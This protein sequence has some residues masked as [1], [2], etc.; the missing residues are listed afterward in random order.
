[1]VATSATTSVEAAP[2]TRRKAI[3]V[4]W[5]A[6]AGVAWL[7]LYA[8]TYLRW[9]TSGNVKPAP[10]GPTPIPTA[11]LVAVWVIEG[12]CVLIAIA[13]VSWFIIRPW[14]RDGHMSRDGLFLMVWMMMFF[15]HDTLFNYSNSVWTYSAAFVNVGSYA[16][17]IPGWQSARAHFMAV[18][19]LFGPGAYCV[20]FCY[21]LIG[22]RILRAAR[23]RWPWM[24]NA[25]IVGCLFL[26][27]LV[28]DVV[29]ESIMLHTGTM[30]Y[31]GSIRWMT[32]FAGHFYQFPV[33]EA[34]T[35]G[36]MQV[37]FGCV[38]FFQNDKGQLVA[39][40]GIEKLTTTAKRRQVWRFLAI[41]GLANCIFAVAYDIPW[42]FFA[43]RTDDW[44]RAVLDKSYMTSG[45]CGIGT[46]Y[47]CPGARVPI[48][49]GPHSAHAT[50]SG[51]L[52]AP[53]GLPVQCP[54]GTIGCDP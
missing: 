3:P 4:K 22:A 33:Y 51:K 48:P 23:S 52:V 49:S 35:L 44:P 30:A 10:R 28:E 18:P 6:A 20:V 24:G 36:G 13:A 21:T 31:A 26:V 2:S 14:R 41:F 19:L 11:H 15:F 27:M 54:V 47:A 46:P 8:I 42:Q 7:T 5:W 39:E 1:M 38:M 9:F 29:F 43:L 12:A 34:L 40:R 50:P 17:S 45:V 53:E 32:L 16:S 25:G 37:A